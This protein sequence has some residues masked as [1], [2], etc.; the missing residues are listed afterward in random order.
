VNDYHKAGEDMNYPPESAD[1]CYDI[2][3]FVISYF[4]AQ[5]FRPDTPPTS[6]TQYAILT[7]SLND[8]AADFRDVVSLALTSFL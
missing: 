4:L 8:P 2:R 7:H 5:A 1:T 6:V 3:L